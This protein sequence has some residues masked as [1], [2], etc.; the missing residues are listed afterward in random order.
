METILAGLKESLLIRGKELSAKTE[1]LSE[2][3]AVLL[4]TALALYN[5]NNHFDGKPLTDEV[6]TNLFILSFIDAILAVLDANNTLSKGHLVS[7]IYGFAPIVHAVYCLLLTEHLPTK[8]L[9]YVMTAISSDDIRKLVSHYGINP[10]MITIESFIPI[11]R[12]I[13]PQGL[14]PIPDSIKEL[15]PLLK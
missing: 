3:D 15:V 5:I 14:S 11:I 10:N 13:S 2:E 4:L 7:D 1:W 9:K 6:G 12:F 8:G